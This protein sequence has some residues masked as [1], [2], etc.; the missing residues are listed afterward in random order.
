M[1]RDT[2]LVVGIQLGT[3]DQ[4]ISIIRTLLRQC[5]ARNRSNILRAH[6][7]HFP[8]SRRSYDRIHVPDTDRMLHL[9][10]IL[11][12]PRWLQDRI[13][14][15]LSNFPYILCDL[16]HHRSI[17]SVKQRSRQQ[18]EAFYAFGDRERDEGAHC[19]EAVHYWG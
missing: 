1:G 7:R 18:D 9:R 17:P 11:H 15:P 8:L 12:K 3:K 16:P 10:E 4:Q 13:L 19:G 2:Y 5:P 6:K 14:D